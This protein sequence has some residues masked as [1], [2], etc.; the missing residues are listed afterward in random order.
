MPDWIAVMLHNYDTGGNFFFKLCLLRRNK[1]LPLRALRT[2][3]IQGAPDLDQKFRPPRTSCCVRRDANDQAQRARAF[4][5]GLASQFKEFTLSFK[6]YAFEF[7][8]GAP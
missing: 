1:D 3:H 6:R 7:R 8:Q 4:K 2:I 5:I